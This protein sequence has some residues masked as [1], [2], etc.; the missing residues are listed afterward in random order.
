MVQKAGTILIN[1]DTNKVAL[2]Y[3]ENENDFS[4]PKGHLEANETLLECAIRETEEEI[5]RK[6]IILDNNPIDI[7]HYKNLKENCEV[8]Y[9]LAKDGGISNNNSLDTHELLW[10]DLDE[11]YDKLSYDNLK[12]LW[13]KA[14]IELEKYRS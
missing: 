13:L 10:I 3:R 9:Y 7:Q 2:I 11:V 4:F 14:K 8:Y 6:C 1:F 12:K 5:K